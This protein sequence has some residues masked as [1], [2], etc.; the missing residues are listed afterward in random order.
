MTLDKKEIKAVKA[1]KD[2]TGI[3][4]TAIAYIFVGLFAIC[5]LLPFLMIISA[6]FSSETAITTEGMGIFPRDFTTEAYGILFRT[7]RY[8]L[9]SY[10]VT[11]TMTVGGTALGLFIISMTGYALQRKDFPF[12]NGISFFIYFTTL[13]SAGLAPTYLWM[14][15]TLQLKNSY[16]AV[17]LP[18]LMTPWLIFLMKNFIKSIPHEIT[19]SGK[20]DGANDF[21]I[22]LTL[23]LPNLKPALAT[24]GLFL[25]LQYWNE[26]YNTMLYISNKDY[27]PLQ[28]YLYKIINQAQALRQSVAGNQVSI[29][30]LPSNTLKMATA[31]VATGPVIL[32]YPF[33]QKYFI[34]GMTVGAVKG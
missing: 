15:N 33:V 32:F 25:A 10:A 5:C 29:E 17:F 28:Y 21:R 26:W 4:I 11:I 2:A 31:I 22:F 9:G 18:L 24:V 12:R 19:E 30:N 1:K 20:I 14:V 23:V 13:F 6:S 27:Q 8:L 16:L 3:V 7:P 34:A